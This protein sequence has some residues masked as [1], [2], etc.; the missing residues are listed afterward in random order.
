MTSP[1]PQARHARPE[2]T[3][4][5]IRLAALMYESIGLDPSSPHWREAARAALSGRHTR[6]ATAVVVDHPAD[7]GRLVASG[8]AVITTRMPSPVN[9]AGRV[10][11]IQWV[12]T[13][14]DWRNRGLARAVVTKL[15]GWLHAREVSRIE[16]H[17]T[18]GGEPLYRSLGFD[19]GKYPGMIHQNGP[20]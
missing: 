20:L 6:D 9:L 4:E 11:Y 16:L 15:M 5:V 2:E 8:A 12:A 18:Q 10:G 3:D 1:S 19:E 17:A 14:P 13:E 7:A